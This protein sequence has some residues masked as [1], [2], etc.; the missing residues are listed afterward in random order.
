MNDVVVPVCETAD[1]AWA[2]SQAIALYRS[3]PARIHLVNVQRPLP[4]HVAQFFNSHDLRA[5]HVEAGLRVL[6]PAVRMLDEA[7]VPHEDH[8]LVGHPAEAIVRFADEHACRQVVID[9]PVKG[10]LSGFG[11]GSIGSQVQHLLQAQART[12][13]NEASRASGSN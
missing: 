8:V 10:L 11:L 9:A 5:F 2:A 3:D 1:A 4:K 12:S 7:G 6:A 13:A